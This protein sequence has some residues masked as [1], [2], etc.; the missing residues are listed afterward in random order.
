VSK[1]YQKTMRSDEHD[2]QDAGQM[3]V[4]EQVIVSL[5]EIAESAKEGLLALSAGV[6]LQA[7]ASADP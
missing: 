6:G 2:R 7:V 4:P 3:A 1:T 5:A